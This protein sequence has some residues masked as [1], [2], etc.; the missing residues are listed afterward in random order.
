M[1][2]INLTIDGK[3]VAVEAGTTVLQAAKKVGVDIPTLCYLDLENTDMLCKPASCRVCVV[4]VVGRRNLCPACATPVAEGMVV[5]TN[6]LRVLEARKTNV[7][8]MISDHPADCLVCPKSGNC[9]LQDLAD[10][11]GVREIRVTGKSQSTYPVSIGKALVRD[12]SKCIMCRRCETMCREV[13]SVNAL[14]GVNR[15]FMA[16]V[17]TSFEE[18][19][20]ET[21]CVG[22]GQCAAVC[23]VGAIMEKDDTQKVIDALLDPDK[24]VV[25]ETAPA[26]R[27]AIGEEFGMEP[28]TIA[29]GKLVTALRNL[30]ADYVFDTDFAADLTIMEE[31][32]E[33][34]ER[35]KK[36]IAGEE[37][38][39]PLMTSC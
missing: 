21:V 16:Y 33:L 34:I 25:F 3:P 4:E 19:L 36:F 29:T 38:D 23:P 8:L 5:K 12:M 14:S 17:G 10:K 9:E 37:A 28:G 26:T 18:P 30:G 24:V 1:S 2:N 7:E 27:V 39:L 22:C 15:G 13:Q 11:V 20:S 32:T 31:G 35:I 6:T